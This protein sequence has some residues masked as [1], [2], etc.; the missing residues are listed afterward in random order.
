MNGE[1]LGF[2]QNHRMQSIPAEVDHNACNSVYA[3]E[4]GNI[5]R[6]QFEL[7]FEERASSLTRS[8]DRRDRERCDHLCLEPDRSLH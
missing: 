1:K 5:E 3:C 2:T 7:Q 6:F 4:K 8:N